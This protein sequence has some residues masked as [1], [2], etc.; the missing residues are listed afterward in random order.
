MPKFTMPRLNLYTFLK[1]KLA[2]ATA[3]NE[4]H[5]QEVASM[6]ASALQVAGPTSSSVSLLLV[7]KP[8]VIPVGK[9]SRHQVPPTTTF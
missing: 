4:R 6:Q 1:K 3:N 7:Q 8:V 9:S 2:S 5:R